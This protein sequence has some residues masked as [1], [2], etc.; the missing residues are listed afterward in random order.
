MNI[1]Q[2]IPEI[3]AEMLLNL[4]YPELEDKWIAHHDG[5]FYRNY[6]RD[7]LSLSPEEAEVSLSRDSILGLLPRNLLSPEE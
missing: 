2:Q 5:T 6:S 3:S 1:S 7:V 4:L